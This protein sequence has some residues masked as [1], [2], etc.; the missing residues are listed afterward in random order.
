MQQPVKEWDALLVEL[1][2]EKLDLKLNEEWKI[3]STECEAQYMSILFIH[4]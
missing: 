3:V 1:I 4:G 2:A